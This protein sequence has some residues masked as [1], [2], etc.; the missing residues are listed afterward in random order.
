MQELKFRRATM[1][2]IKDYRA[3]RRQYETAMIQHRRMEKAVIALIT[4]TIAAIVIIL[5]VTFYYSFIETGDS[6]AFAVRQEQIEKQIDYSI[7]LQND[8]V[9]AGEA[10]TAGR[11]R[12]YN[13]MKGDSR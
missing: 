9:N 3:I 13:S 12:R 10:G 11:S 7:S 4:A 8:L 5:G 1:Q 6:E 2:E